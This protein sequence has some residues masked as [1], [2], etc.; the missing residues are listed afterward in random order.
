MYLLLGV[1]MRALIENMKCASER[2][3]MGAWMG[4]W[5]GGLVSWWVGFVIVIN[6]SSSNLFP[7][8]LF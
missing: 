2:G 6:S 5:V 8:E 4:G 7:F 3:C 1:S